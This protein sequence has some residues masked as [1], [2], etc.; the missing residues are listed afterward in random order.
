MAQPRTMTADPMTLELLLATLV[1]H[2]RK[3]GPSYLFFL[4]LIA[5]TFVV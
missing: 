3:D 4:V 1:A 5:V 2:A